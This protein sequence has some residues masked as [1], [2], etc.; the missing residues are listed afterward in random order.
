[1]T[2][3]LKNISPYKNL[4]ALPSTPTQSTFTS[5][6]QRKMPWVLVQMQA[7]PRPSPENSQCHRAC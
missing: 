5:R 1:V 6:T 4:G 3:Y 2:G 7:Y